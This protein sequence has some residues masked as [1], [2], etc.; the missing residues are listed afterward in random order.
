MTQSEIFTLAIAAFFVLLIL[1]IVF[2]SKNKKLMNQAKLNTK[3]HDLVA[4]HYPTIDVALRFG[5]IGPIIFG[6]TLALQAYGKTGGFVVL[7]LILFLLPLLH[8]AS[9]F[10]QEQARQRE[11]EGEEGHKEKVKLIKK[12]CPTDYNAYTIIV[13]FGG[14][15][16]GVYLSDFGIYQAITFGSLS[17]ILFAPLDHWVHH[18]FFEKSKLKEQAAD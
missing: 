13:C 18:K 8:M 2:A 5:F 6:N 11:A 9:L 17:F 10:L 3:K 1:S 16:L 15:F 14:S 4:K 7:G 12:H